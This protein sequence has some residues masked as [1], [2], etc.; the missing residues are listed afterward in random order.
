MHTVKQMLRQPLKTLSG[1][2]LMTLAVAVLCVCVGQSFAANTTAKTL[3]ERF[4]TIAIPAGLQR[5][6]E[7]VI[8]SSVT[9]P[10]DLTRWLEDAA[11]A[12]PD[13]VQGI[14][15]QGLISAYVP[16][17]TAL[18]YTQGKYIAETFTS[19][20]FAFHFYEPSPDGTPYACA[21]LVIT[22]EEVS[23][24]T[25][26]TKTY[27]V[28]KPMEISDFSSYAEYM[29]YQ[30][31]A[32]KENVTVSY[33]ITL[34]GTVSE[35]VSL[36]EGFRDPTG[37][38]ARLTMTVPDLAQLEALDLRP[39]QRYLVYGTDYCDEDWAFRSLLAHEDSR[40]RKVIDAFDMSRMHVLT[41]EERAEYTGTALYARYDG[42]MLTK[43]EYDRVNA[44][45]MT[46]SV[47]VSAHQYEEERDDAGTLLALNEV[48]DIRCTAPDG[49]E[50][51]LDRDA[52]I[53]RYTIP[54]IAALDGSAEAFLQTD[55][56]AAW[57]AALA[58]DAVNNA[59]F[60]VIGVEKLGYMADFAREKAQI[61]SGRGFTDVET[62]DGLRV[63]VLHEA[64]A[65]ANGLQV[66]DAIT[67]RFYQAD[68][69]NPYQTRGLL[70]P[71]AALYFDTTPFTEEAEYTI[72]GLYRTDE[73]W[74]DVSEDEYGFSPNTLFVPAASVETPME[75]VNSVLYTTP[76][77]RNG[78]METFRALAA[79]AGYA[80]RFVYHDQGYSL[81][82]GN[83]HRYAALAQQVLAIGAAVY[84]VILMLFLL[85]YPR[86]QRRTVTTMEAL[87]VPR[88]MR[89]THVLRSAAVVLVHATVF[90]SA[91]GMLLW[92]SAVNAL[93]AS[94]ETTVSLQL[95][96]AALLCIALTQLVF[97]MLCSAVLSARISAP[98][99]LSARRS[100]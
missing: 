49:T 86:A 46:L 37:M 98:K 25:A 69:A 88:R 21:M 60:A 8:Q 14:M 95:D 79:E 91:L 36:Q 26:N 2:V 24:P 22:L 18:N 33:T 67:L 93:K 23:A 20:N 31:A 65:A 78:Q 38:T 74:C 77:I 72:V 7:L 17:V 47:P 68:A 96:I 61:V 10:D 90:G 29:A 28:E 66:G 44:I 82:A 89:L 27:T 76:V 3:D 32:R 85:L 42:L 63:C 40:T 4:T 15:H 71:S 52:Y 5:M 9:L 39:G 57:R 35:V 80:D 1:I 92:Q 16:G 43:A 55:E 19:G 45:S 70:N 87:G 97:A 94:V 59:A 64:L 41:E 53:R 12:H 83:F 51:V 56:G 48:T 81:I 11:A 62:S 84:A 100:K 50:T 99:G 30:A 73:M 13:V 6:E 58:R 34:S 54:T 75:S